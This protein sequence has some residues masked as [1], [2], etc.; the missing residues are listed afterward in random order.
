ME[1]IRLFEADRKLIQDLAPPGRSALSVLRVHEYMQRKPLIN[2]GQTARALDLSVPTVS[3]ALDRLEGLKIVHETTGRERG[4]I[5][6]YTQYLR[7]VA[8]GTEPI[9]P[10]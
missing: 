9:R 4:R 1:L 8:S 10:S 3:L 2:I 7:I 5:F 6:A